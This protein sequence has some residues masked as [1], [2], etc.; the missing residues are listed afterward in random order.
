MARKLAPDTLILLFFPRFSLE[1]NYFEQNTGG[2][3]YD[4]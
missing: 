3:D 1:N 2:Q 4:Q